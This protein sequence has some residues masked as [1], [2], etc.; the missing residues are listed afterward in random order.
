MVHLKN[1][2]TEPENL[3][4]VIPHQGFSD[5]GVFWPLASGTRIHSFQISAGQSVQPLRVPGADVLALTINPGFS[6]TY[7]LELGAGG[8]HGLLLWHRQAWDAQAGSQAFF[9]GAV[10]GIAILL[11]IAILC[12]FIVRRRAVFPA[13][14]LF[15]GPAVAFLA[16]E[17]GYLGALAAWFPVQASEDQLR[18][19]IEGLMLAGIAACLV[20]FLELR[21]R[22]PAVA[23][24]GVGLMGVAL[25]LVGYGQVNPAIATGVIRV[26][27]FLLVLAGF[28]VIASLWRDRSVRAQG[29]LIVWSVLTAW[30]LIAT[31]DCLGL[32]T[33]RLSTP[34]T[35]AGLVLVLLT[36][37]FTVTQF[38]FG[39]VMA[40]GRS[41]EDISPAR[42][43]AC[44]F[45]AVGLGL[46]SRQGLPVRR[47]RTRTFPWTTSR[48]LWVAAASTAW[49]QLIHSFRSLGISGDAG[50][51]RT[52]TAR[53]A[54][55][56]IP[57]ASRRW[58]L[59]LV[60][61]A[62]AGHPRR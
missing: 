45:R 8:L 47:P 52:P 1:P 19:A 58:Q 37:A 33:G 21:R 22:L 3:V 60:S 20:T 5:S 36:M 30:T 50:W 34:V 24:I 35:L 53:C 29:S 38:A 4:L 40:S 28:G 17:M 7:A 56:G 62:G 14:A 2:K 13:A 25:A 54:V 11:A 26:L 6:V 16:A 27:F 39:S 61:A 55:A 23:A 44:Q 57:P 49:I 48:E 59:S 32:M 15:A 18:A 46:A 41:F 10:L 12:L 9:N 42:P 31:A 51:R 43:G